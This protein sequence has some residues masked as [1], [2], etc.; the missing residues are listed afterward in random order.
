VFGDGI[1]GIIRGDEGFGWEQVS[2]EISVRSS[3]GCNL[4]ADFSNL[5][6]YKKYG[7]SSQ[8]MP[9]HLHRSRGETL[10]TWRDRLYHEFRIPIIL[11][12]L[13][14]LKLSYLEQ[15]NPLLSRVILL[16]VRRLP[17]NLRTGKALFKKIVVSKS[18][19]I[20]FAASSAVASLGEIVRQKEIANFLKNELSSVETK[21][22]FPSDFLKFVL[23]GMRSGSDE[24]KLKANSSSI[25]SRIK[26]HLPYFLKAALKKV[27]PKKLDHNIL[28]FRVF[29]IT[30]MNRILNESS[31][32]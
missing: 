13:S 28:A 1:E 14:D 26:K 22:L 21:K 15:I 23:D 11:A 31:S 9:Q 25:K 19:K 20:D 2:N 7:F 24:K 5:K 30:S 8:E 27:A 12:A 4:C 32:K 10:A 18:P 3:I 6:D 16:Q 17:D 29:V